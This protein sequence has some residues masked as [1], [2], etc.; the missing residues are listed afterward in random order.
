VLV[1]HLLALMV[2]KMLLIILGQ[3]QVLVVIVKLMLTVVLFYKDIALLNLYNKVVEILKVRILS[4]RTYGGIQVI[5][6]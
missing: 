4:A 3:E 1:V 6:V 5:S 2:I